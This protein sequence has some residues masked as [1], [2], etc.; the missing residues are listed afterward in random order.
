MKK[1][2]SLYK[3]QG[4]H[5]ITAIFTVEMGITKVLLVKRK[6]EPYKGDWIL[7]GGALYNNEDLEHGAKREIF[8]KTGI[9][10]IEI[11]QFKTFG[12]V[13]RSPV[14]RMI[15]VAYV[16]VIDSNRVKIIRET[17]NTSNAD[18]FP[19]DKIPGLG[20][21]HEEIVKESL[22]FLQSK[23]VSSDILKALFPNE[24]TLPEIQKTYEAI[25]NRKFDRRNFRKKLLSL[26]L[27]E[28][29][30][31]TGKFEGKKPAKLYCF[32]KIIE[33]KKV[34]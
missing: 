8:E 14:M 5:V 34:F 9:E 31:K 10:N 21:D 2:N 32:K 33:N 24:F 26:N 6:N 23:I 18:W 12:K 22:L 25:L 17:T 7:T 19:I 20:F 4:I 30:N 1:G 3:G 11:E 13:D 29:T 16:G 27:I 28:D 15:A